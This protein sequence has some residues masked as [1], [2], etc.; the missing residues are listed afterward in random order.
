MTTWTNLFL[1]VKER[2]MPYR[3]WTE[4]E[5]LVLE[6]MRLQG[7]TSK[8]IGQR[9]D[10]TARAVAEKASELGLPK[11]LTRRMEWIEALEVP[12]DKADVLKRLGAKKGTY[13]RMKA[14]LKKQGYNLPNAK[15]KRKPNVQPTE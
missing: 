12:H 8:E 9:L 13:G 6:E 3:E 15:Y 5:L 2:V 11:L 1:R 14:K 10:R 4:R 7:R